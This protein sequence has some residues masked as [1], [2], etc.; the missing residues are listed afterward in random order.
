MTSFSSIF[1]FD[2]Y[3]FM[4]KNFIQNYL[5]NVLYPEMLVSTA[6][7]TKAD[8]FKMISKIVVFVD[9]LISPDIWAKNRLFES[10]L[11][12]T[13]FSSKCWYFWIYEQNNYFSMRSKENTFSLNFDIFGDM[14]KKRLLWSQKNFLFLELLIFT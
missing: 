6:K 3:E 14:D 1:A 7:W 4:N 5:K 10:D 9:M 13:Y 8:F 12:I 11:T 2:I